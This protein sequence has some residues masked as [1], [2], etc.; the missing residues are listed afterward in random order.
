MPEEIR[1][2]FKDVVSESDEIVRE[3]KIPVTLAIPMGF[4]DQLTDKG[5]NVLES[6]LIDT[7]DKLD[8]TALCIA[9]LTLLSWNLKAQGIERK[10]DIVGKKLTRLMEYI[11]ELTQ[12]GLKEHSKLI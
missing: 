6:F 4:V 2:K 8:N 3:F 11:T 12:I 5:Q 9:I 10:A 1:F 7:K